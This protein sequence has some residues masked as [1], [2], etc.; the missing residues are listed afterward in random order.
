[1]GIR[2]ATRVAARHS[3]A[4]SRHSCAHSRHSCAGSNL[5]TVVYLYIPAS[6]IA[7]ASPKS[8]YCWCPTIETP[9]RYIQVSMRRL[10]PVLR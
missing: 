4:H 3:C 6:A 2:Q 1:M 7:P 9:H 8:T 5:V 10:A